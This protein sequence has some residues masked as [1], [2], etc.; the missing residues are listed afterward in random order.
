MEG[1]E[2][3]HLLRLNRGLEQRHFSCRHRDV[4]SRDGH[5]NRSDQPVADDLHH[6]PSQ[7][8]SGGRCGQCGILP[9]RNQFGTRYN[10]TIHNSSEF[11]SNGE[12]L[13]DCDHHG[14]EWRQSDCRSRRYFRGERRARHREATRGNQFS[15]RWSARDYLRRNIKRDS[16]R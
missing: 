12:L 16:E 6:Q 14:Q 15:C 2:V 7:H 9:G 13:V 10:R 3:S 8:N 1:H 4:R 5:G 11:G